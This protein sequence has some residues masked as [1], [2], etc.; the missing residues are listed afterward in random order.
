MTI[1]KVPIS[2]KQ[3]HEQIRPV[4]AINAAVDYLDEPKRQKKFRRLVCIGRQTIATKEL[5][6]RINLPPLPLLVGNKT[7]RESMKVREKS[8][9]FK[10]VASAIGSKY[11]FLKEEITDAIQQEK[12][13]VFVGQNDFPLRIELT[14]DNLSEEQEVV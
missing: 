5:I 2:T 6:E 4:R 3:L 13:K 12:E 14:D 8:P 7:L 1:R 9:L 10:V 11:Q